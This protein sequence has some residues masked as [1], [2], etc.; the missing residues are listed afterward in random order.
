MATAYLLIRQTL[1]DSANEL[2][3]WPFAK[4]LLLRVELSVPAQIQFTVKRE[5]ELP[6]EIHGIFLNSE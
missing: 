5:A 1:D 2:I 4:P 6:N 3:C